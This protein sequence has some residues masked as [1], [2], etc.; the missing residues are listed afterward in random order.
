MTAL[1]IGVAG[2]AGRMGREIISTV[3]AEQNNTVILSAALES[4]QNTAIGGDVGVLA[5]V[6]KCGV[7]VNTLEKLG[8]SPFD[9]LIDFSTPAATVSHA[10]FCAAGNIALVIG[11]TGFGDEQKKRIRAAAQKIALVMSPNMSLGVNAL[12]AL[13]DTAARLLKAGRLGGGYDIEVFEA[14]HRRKKDAP[15]GTALRLGE[16]LANAT[17]ATLKQDAVFDR[18]GLRG[19]NDIGFSVVRG[20]DIVGEHRVIF[21][22]GGEQLELIHRSTSRANYATGAVQAAKFAATADAGLYDMTPV[23]NM[24]A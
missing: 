9:V 8:A 20:G 19:D 14:H 3:L 1:R 10:D 7:L 22:G 5:G 24:P 18:Q 15:S 2:A 21:A 16:A 11:V 23:I 17:G 6:G 12:F 4:S 13:A